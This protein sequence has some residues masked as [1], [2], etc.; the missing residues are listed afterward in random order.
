MDML[1]RGACPWVGDRPLF[2]LEVGNEEEEGKRGDDEVDEEK[3][4]QATF[5]PGRFFIKDLQWFPRNDVD[6]LDCVGSFHRG[7]HSPLSSTCE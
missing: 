2:L 7:C 5:L 6:H 4:K 3:R 1:K